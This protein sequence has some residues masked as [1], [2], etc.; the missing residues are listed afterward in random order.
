MEPYLPLLNTLLTMRLENFESSR[1]RLHTPATHSHI[2]THRTHANVVT[3]IIK[4]I[5][6]VDK[7]F[8]S[9]LSPTNAR[10]L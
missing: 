4:L 7:W 10:L 6:A 8:V 9:D 3:I 2:H 5:M 1:R